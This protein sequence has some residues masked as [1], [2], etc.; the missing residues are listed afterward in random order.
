MFDDDFDQD[1]Q[2]DEETPNET[3][4]FFKRNDSTYQKSNN[5]E[6]VTHN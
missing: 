4:K 3:R 2:D 6:V 5:Y 1:D